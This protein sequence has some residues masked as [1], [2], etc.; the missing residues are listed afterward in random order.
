MTVTIDKA[1]RVVVPK[2]VR[3]R[4]AWT[5]GTE[6]EVEVERDGLKLRVKEPHALLAREDGLLVCAAAL[7]GG[8]DP[9]AF[10]DE[11][12]ER[13]TATVGGWNPR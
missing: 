2:P 10:A 4:F 6:V 5:P 13:R 8:F 1:G 3:D 7:P 12:R 9:L 11:E